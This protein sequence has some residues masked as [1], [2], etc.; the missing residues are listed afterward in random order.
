MPIRQTE[1][2]QPFFC[3]V[4]WTFQVEDPFRG[5]GTGRFRGPDEGFGFEGIPKRKIQSQRDPSCVRNIT[6]GDS[7]GTVRLARACVVRACSDGASVASDI[8]IYIYMYIQVFGSPPPMTGF[9]WFFHACLHVCGTVCFR[10]VTTQ[11]PTPEVPWC[12]NLQSC[13]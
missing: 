7:R 8:Y 10:D 2:V 6:S 12:V 1:L 3:L 11:G 4:S 5:P 13:L 9:S